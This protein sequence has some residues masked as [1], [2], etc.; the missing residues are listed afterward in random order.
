MTSSKGRVFSGECVLD[1]RNVA[2]GFLEFFTQEH[3][4]APLE[5]AYADFS[6]KNFFRGYFRGISCIAHGPFGAL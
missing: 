3:A 5:K 4:V 6:S 1:E 2:L